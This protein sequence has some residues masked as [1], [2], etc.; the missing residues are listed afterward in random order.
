[1]EPKYNDKTLRVRGLRDL[2]FENFF[3]GGKIKGLYTLVLEKKGLCY[4]F[5]LEK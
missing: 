5:F 1:M 2:I 4:N 3:K